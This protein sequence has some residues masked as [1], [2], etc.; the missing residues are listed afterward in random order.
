IGPV[1]AYAMRISYVG[2]AGYEIHFP[3]D[4]ALVVFDRLW[5]VANR[6]GAVMAGS[7]AMDSL[8]LEKGYRLWGVDIHTE[9]D[10]YS[11]GLGWTLRPDDGFVGAAA[12]GR[13]SEPGATLVCLRLDGGDA[14]GNEPVLAEGAVVGYVTS[15]AF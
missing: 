3:V 12:A 15:A 5:Q 9:H 8:R 1:P 14:L 11:A 10:P 6:M 7:G 13:R 2:E 4:Q